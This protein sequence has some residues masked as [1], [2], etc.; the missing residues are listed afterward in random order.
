MNRREAL[1]RARLLVGARALAREQIESGDGPDRTT[2][3]LG[4]RVAEVAALWGR[5]FPSWPEALADLEAQVRRGR[6]RA[7]A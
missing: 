4:R 1:A 2:V 7:A 6:R 5:A 3:Q